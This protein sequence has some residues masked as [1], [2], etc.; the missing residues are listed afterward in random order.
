MRNAFEMNINKQHQD[1][2]LARHMREGE[3]RRRLRNSQ[4][5]ASADGQSMLDQVVERI[6]AIG[7]NR[8]MSEAHSM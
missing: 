1:I 8:R 5:S 3:N 6:R 7:K 2:A 4:T